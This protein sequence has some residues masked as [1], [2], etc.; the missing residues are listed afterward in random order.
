MIKI[1]KQY[2]LNRYSNEYSTYK[3]QNSSSGWVLCNYFVRH[4]LGY[5]PIAIEVTVSTHRIRRK[6]AVKISI[7]KSED[8]WALDLYG[9]YQYARDVLD[10]DF[11]F[12]ANEIRHIYVHLKPL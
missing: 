4:A 11:N 6:T 3:T 8:R 12:I 7:L 2:T 10:R 1:T 5:A 9:L